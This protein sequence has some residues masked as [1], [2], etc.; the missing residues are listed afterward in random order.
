MDYVQQ[1]L[2]DTETVSK[3]LGSNSLKIVEVDYDPENAYRQGHLQGASLIWWKR[4][5]NDP[6]TRDIVSKSQFE[7][8]LS[9]N[10]ITTQSEVILYGDFNNWFA[11]FV[12]W[13]FKYYGHENVKIMNGGRKKWEIENRSYT[14]DEPQIQKT[15]YVAQP[16]NEGLRAYLFDVRRSLDKKDTVLVDVRSPK[17]FSGEI[18]APAEYPMEHAQRGGHIPN[19]SNI[20][21]ASAVN[22]TDGTFKSVEELKKIYETKG[23]T[24]DKDVICYCRIGERSSHTWF[25]LKY[26][27]GYPQVRN[28]DGS[29]TEWGN[30]I[31][32]PIEK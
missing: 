12:F 23:I 16:P 7:D 31:G 14:K 29:W 2:V 1:V 10:G 21:W 6:I 15:N 3:N 22:D 20:P 19:A 11:A 32:N 8:L 18:T 13:I 24:P 30:M 9:R 28:Y 25:V 17:E 26:L 5:I 4:D 27:L